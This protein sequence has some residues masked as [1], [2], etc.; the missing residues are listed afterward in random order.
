MQDLAS[1]P[2]TVSLECCRLADRQEPHKANFCLEFRP[3][4]KWDQAELSVSPHVTVPCC[5]G[6]EVSLHQRAQDRACGLPVS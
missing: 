5:L 1:V 6:P 3:R 2:L 4:S